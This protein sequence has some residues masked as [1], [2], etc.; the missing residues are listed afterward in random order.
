MNITK[1]GFLLST[2]KDKLDIDVIHQFLSN[3]YWAANIPHDVVKKSLEHSLCFGIYKD[4]QLAG[5][6]RTITDYATF[7]Y[8]AD[9]FILDEFRGNGLSKWLVDCI[10]QHP[11]LQ[12][13]RRWMLATKDAHK[14]YSQYAGFV[15]IASPEM[16][17][18][19]TTSYNKE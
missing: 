6:A 12:G 19:I 15:P 16:W 10:R 1:N 8:L 9:V 7:A 4:K 13:L 18:E 5:F 3:S 17:M 11:D 2:D 14:L